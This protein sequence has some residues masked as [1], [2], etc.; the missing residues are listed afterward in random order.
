MGGLEEWVSVFDTAI[1]FKYNINRYGLFEVT[2][3]VKDKKR[4]IWQ[5]IAQKRKQL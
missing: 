4:T 3:I 1:E 5:I 2:I